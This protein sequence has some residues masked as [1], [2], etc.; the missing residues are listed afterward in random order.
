MNKTIA[1]DW[2]E[3]A[4]CDIVVLES[5]KDNDFITHMIAFH[6]QQTIEKSFKA[7]LEHYEN[8]VPHKHDL[9]MLNKLISKYLTVDDTYILDALNQL[10]IDSRYPGSFG[11]LPYGKPTLE[12]AKEFYEFADAIFEQTCTLL[13]I[14]INEI[15]VH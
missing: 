1:K 8:S 11:L 9:L 14:S 7:M 12:D 15:K 3:A 5:I 4:Y 6:A 10:Y 2:L 13:G